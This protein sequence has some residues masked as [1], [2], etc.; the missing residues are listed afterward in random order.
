M[1]DD[2]NAVGGATA[3]VDEFCIRHQLTIQKLPLSHVP[4]FLTWTNRTHSHK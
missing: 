1:V 3:A 2:Y 4:A